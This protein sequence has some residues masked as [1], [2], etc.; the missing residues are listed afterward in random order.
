[1][2]KV[3][4]E[5][6]TDD[7]RLVEHHSDGSK[8]YRCVTQSCIRD[9]VEKNGKQK[10]DCADCASDRLAKA[11]GGGDGHQYSIDEL[12]R[13]LPEDI[14]EEVMS[15][16][17]LN[18]G[19][20][21]SMDEVGKMAESLYDEGVIEKKEGLPPSHH[22]GDPFDMDATAV[23]ISGSHESMGLLDHFYDSVE[24]R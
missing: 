12:R 21:E 1:M 6:L 8:S 13:R 3:V 9:H 24:G 5:H 16:I 4:K 19:P 18:D 14:F 10:C 20:P 15:Y 2:P 22:L 23:K 11:T 7:G 17:D